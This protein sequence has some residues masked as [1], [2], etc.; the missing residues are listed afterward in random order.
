MRLRAIFAWETL[1]PRINGENPAT[2]LLRFAQRA[3]VLQ[4]EFRT[5]GA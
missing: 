1:L 4:L 3:A 2:F 5:I